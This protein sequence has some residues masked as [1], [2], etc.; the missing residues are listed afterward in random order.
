MNSDYLNPFIEPIFNKKKKS[1][2]GY[3]KMKMLV[4]RLKK[5]S[6]SFDMMIDIYDFLI[7]LDKLYLYNN[8]NHHKLFSATFP[9]GYDAAIIY[10]EEWFTIKYILRKSDRMIGINIEKTCNNKGGARDKKETIQFIEGQAEINNKYDEEKFL[11]II[12]CLMNGLCE[13]IEYYYI[14]KMI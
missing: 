5:T 4:R 8:N 12:S 1:I 3:I 10:K 11:F 14:N 6:P 7:L 2:I 13:L 9:G